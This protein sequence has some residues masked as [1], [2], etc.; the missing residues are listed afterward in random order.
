MAPVRRPELPATEPRAAGGADPS[1]GGQRRRPARRARPAAAPPGVDHQRHGVGGPARARLVRFRP[2]APPRRALPPAGP[3]DAGADLLGGAAE[4]LCE[5]LRG[6][7]P[8]GSGDAAARRHRAPGSGGLP[9]GAAG[10]PV[11]TLSACP[12]SGPLAARRA[13]QRRRATVLRAAT[14][15]G[16]QRRI[17]RPAALQRGALRHAHRPGHAGAL[18]RRHLAPAS[19]LRAGLAQRRPGGA[20]AGRH[21]GAVVLER[22]APGG[23]DGDPGGGDLRAVFHP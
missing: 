14:G 19:G 9:G 4:Y 15:A 6:A 10:D 7:S 20:G 21:G 23:V 1:G 22:G 2:P 8:P 12:G 18:A 16:A 5:P 17:V 13:A 3:R 11:G